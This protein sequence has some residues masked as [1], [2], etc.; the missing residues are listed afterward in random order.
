LFVVF[1]MMKEKEAEMIQP[2]LSLAH[3]IVAT[4]V[5]NQQRSRTAGQLMDIILKQSPDQSVEA[6]SSP[7]QALETVRT[8]VGPKD[9]I[10]IAGSLYLIA[11][12][13]PLF[14]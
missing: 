4:E 8:Q 12:I 2:L 14:T 10:V 7:E 6:I 11:Q 5:P 13:R 3:H 1:A 9:M